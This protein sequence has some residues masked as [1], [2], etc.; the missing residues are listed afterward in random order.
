MVVDINLTPTASHIQIARTLGSAESGSPELAKPLPARTWGTATECAAGAILVHGLGAHSGWFEAL[1][2]RLRI[3]RI[4]SIAYDQVGFGKR[5]EESFTS[6]TQWLEDLETAYNYA[7]ETIGDKPLFI[8]G[9]SMGAV[10]SVRALSDHRVEPAGLVMFSP[11]FD[12]HPDIFTL[13]FRIKALWQAFT[14]P[15]S[16]VILPYSPELVT[17]DL[18]VRNW[19]LNDPERRFTVPA[20]MLLELLK[21]TNDLGKRSRQ[22]NCPV[23]MLNAGIEKIVNP[24]TSEKLFNGLTCDKEKYLYAEA[25]HDLMF[26]PI[27]DEMCDQLTKWIAQT[28]KVSTKK[29]QANFRNSV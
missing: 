3:R 27:I 25:W 28:S 19:I 22:I 7:R 26:D 14:D 8:M 24:R 12:G 5:K 23:L 6:Y 18:N 16:E 4:Y 13:P 2:R 1:G 9:N 15:E 17:R 21:V 11:G 10:V 20:R 29:F